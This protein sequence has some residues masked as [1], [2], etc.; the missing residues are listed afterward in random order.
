M[1]EQSGP[2]EVTFQDFIFMMSTSALVGLGHVPNPVT[3]KYETDLESVRQ[4]ISLLT[5]IQ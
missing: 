5:M 3:N 4:T 2:R 1:N